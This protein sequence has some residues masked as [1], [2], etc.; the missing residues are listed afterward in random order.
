MTNPTSP[1]VQPTDA[2]PGTWGRPV[3]VLLAAVAAVGMAQAAT[4]ADMVKVWA[5]SE[6]YSYAWAALPAAAFVAWWHRRDVRRAPP[7]AS[8]WGVGLALAA[9][10]LWLAGEIVQIGAARHAGIALGLAALVVASL[11]LVCARRLLPALVL[12]AFIVPAGDVLLLPLRLATV[13]F[14]ELYA[15][16]AAVPYARDGFTLILDSYRYVVVDDCAGLPFVLMGAFVGTVFGG[17]NTRTLWKVLAFGALGALLGVLG[18]GARVIAIVASD[19]INGTQMTLSGHRVYEL[20]A[21]AIVFGGLLLT[22]AVVRAEPAPTAGS[23][24]AIPAGWLRTL[25]L[26]AL[27]ALVLSAGPLMISADPATGRTPVADLPERTAGWQAVDSV[28]EWTPRARAA[29]DSRQRS[30]RAADGTLAVLFVARALD[31]TD[32]IS[33][34]SVNL[35]TTGGAANWMHAVQRQIQLC[36]TAGCV[37][38]IYERQL[39]Q[40]SQRA[41]H[42]VWHYKVAGTVTV[43]PLELRLARSW[44]RVI[45]R[46]ADASLAVAMQETENP[47][48]P[49]LSDTALLD[50]LRTR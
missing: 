1:L 36:D 38:A 47:D 4:V 8:W 46:P 29:A 13:G 6:T 3:A 16:A 35:H 11:G 25:G 22:H 24:A 5:A 15:L 48:A 7:R 34:G 20:I 30:Y 31:P 42:L 21:F 23:D 10:L 33:A 27:A 41:R 17:L 44:G 32:K 39:L 2:M 26:P 49:R 12:L 14:V 50:L 43:S 19:Q 45:G 18:N 37:P 40:G 9:G 28:S